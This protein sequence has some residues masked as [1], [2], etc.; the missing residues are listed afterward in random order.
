MTKSK[1]Y[2]A[3]FG[4]KRNQIPLRAKAQQAKVRKVEKAQVDMRIKEATSKLRQFLILKF[5]EGHFTATTVAALAF[6]VSACGALGLDDLAEDP[7]SLNFSKNT[8]RKVSTALGIPELRSQL[9]LL[10]LPC[11]NPDSADRT[12]EAH[13]VVS[14]QHALTEEFQ[15]NAA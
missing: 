2:A 9:V 14:L 1:G 4:H 13:E 5:C 10:S 11:C 15:Q 3:A 6:H 8:S 7:H 12:I